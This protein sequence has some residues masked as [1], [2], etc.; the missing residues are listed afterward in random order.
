MSKIAIK[1][2]ATGA[3]VFT[4]EAPSTATSRTLTL[5]DSA[6]E[7]LNPTALRSELNASGSAPIYAARAWVNFDGTAATPSIRASG[8]VSSITDDGTGLYKV[9]L[10]TALS[11]TNYAICGISSSSTEIGSTAAHTQTLV[12][13]DAVTRTTSVFG[14]VNRGASGVNNDRPF[15]SVAVFS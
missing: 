14:V 2:G 6:G 1:G 9:N 7:L 13:R 4:L 12:E 10:T 3:A 11:D 5:P 15:I 8:N